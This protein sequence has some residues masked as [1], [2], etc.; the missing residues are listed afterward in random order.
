[1]SIL[2]Q[3][4]TAFFT[5]CFVGSN[6]ITQAQSLTIEKA[7]VAIDNVNIIDSLSGNGGGARGQTLHRADFEITITSGNAAL[8]VITELQAGLTRNKLLTAELNIPLSDGGNKNIVKRIY[9]NA[10][11]RKI[12]LPELNASVRSN[13]KII[14][15][16][17]AAS[18][19][20]QQTGNPDISGKNTKVASVNNYRIQVGSLPCNRISKISEMKIGSQ[21]G[22]PTATVQLSGAD[23]KAWND[24]FDNGANRVIT[25]GVVELLSPD[26][27]TVILSINLKNISIVAYKTK[28]SSSEQIAKATF[29][30]KMGSV[31]I[32]TN[33][34]N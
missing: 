29:E 1:M 7:T 34:V 6:S 33:P 4:G 32:D 11:V 8:K 18:I 16:I 13:F 2:K 25:D 3:L 30:L 9:K 22:L 27:K 26:L 23:E 14:V 10:A 31:L 24:Q 17:E 12:I 28:I 19:E 15:T 21:P 5:L 20:V